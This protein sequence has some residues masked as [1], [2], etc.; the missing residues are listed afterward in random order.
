MYSK[1]HNHGCQMRDFFPNFFETNSFFSVVGG[2][3]LKNKIVFLTGLELLWNFWDYVGHKYLFFDRYIFSKTLKIWV[4]LTSDQA[5]T[6]FWSSP[7][8]QAGFATSKLF[9]SFTESINIFW[10]EKA[11]ALAEFFIDLIWQHYS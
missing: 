3:E 1:S 5:K 9:V 7:Q 4:K 2:L 11:G 8:S 10:G 6:Y